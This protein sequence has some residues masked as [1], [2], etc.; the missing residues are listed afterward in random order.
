MPL[1]LLCPLLHGAQGGPSFSPP[2]PLSHP[3]S[4]FSVPCAP[5]AFQGLSRSHFPQSV[6]EIAMAV[7]HVVSF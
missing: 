4:S 1:I 2:Q 5:H 7:S 3:G 6:S